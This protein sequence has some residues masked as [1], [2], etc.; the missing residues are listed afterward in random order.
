MRHS[1]RV[2][3]AAGEE[4]SLAAIDRVDMGEWV[5]AVKEA[6]SELA[7]AEARN[8]DQKLRFKQESEN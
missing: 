2:V 7:D 6:V 1:F 4:L 5:A 3:N 8:D